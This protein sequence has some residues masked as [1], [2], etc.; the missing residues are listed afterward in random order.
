M[1]NVQSWKRGSK[2]SL[3]GS[4]GIFSEKSAEN[5]HATQRQ[6]VYTAER[7]ALGRNEPPVAGT[8]KSDS[9]KALAAAQP[10]IPCQWR[11]HAARTLPPRAKG[12]ISGLGS[13]EA[14]QESGASVEVMLD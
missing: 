9:A 10:N 2:R 7:A 4:P 13:G 3:S 1:A 12:S 5:V 8:S 11:S 14:A 6:S